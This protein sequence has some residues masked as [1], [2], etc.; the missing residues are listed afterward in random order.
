MASSNPS[1][2]ARSRVILPGTRY[3]RIRRIV[4]AFCVTGFILLPMFDL[5]RFDLLRKRFY[6]FGAELWV[7]EFAILFLSM[8]FFFI[9]FAASAMIYGRFWCSYLCPQMI[10][11]DAANSLAR[12]VKKFVKRNF[13][14][15][16]EGGQKALTAILF[17]LILLPG[18]VFV[19]FVF[20]AYFIPPADLFQ[21]LMHFDVRTAG[22]IVGA[23]VTLVTFLD[24]AL[25]RERFCVNICPYGYLQNMLADKNTLLV[26]FD[27]PDGH[28]INCDKCVRT[29]PM[30][31]DIRSSSHQLECTHC[32]E[33]I[34]AC[35]DI[36][37]K[38]GR[39]STIHYA[40]GKAG[41]LDA[42]EKKWWRKLGVRD[43]KRFAI[44]TLLVLYFTG[45]S[46]AIGLRQPV[47]VQIMPNRITLYT[48]DQSGLVHNRF[49]LLASNRG[50]KPATLSLAA[51]GLNG[52]AI[53]GIGSNVP[54]APGDTVQQEFDVI[55]PRASLAP[56]VNHM[57][58][59]A[60][61]TPGQTEQIDETFLAPM[62]GGGK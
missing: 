44:L 5:M 1:A 33:C 23:S 52:A 45:L 57:R 39:Q 51:T 8:M 7:S 22:G 36:L 24:F 27:D 35:S 19:S 53:E 15:L 58:I 12:R 26:A 47:L 60:Q 28:C 21:R 46:I 3:H 29:C 40:W 30:G 17:S 42:G 62:E 50:H 10:F 38:L 37:G 6:F 18:A 61:V 20:V 25:L 31:I 9:L 41:R 13:S 4:Q 49:R 34:D 48:V 11:S 32:G 16:A 56:G 55:V 2:P 14:S 59:V 54:L 43:G